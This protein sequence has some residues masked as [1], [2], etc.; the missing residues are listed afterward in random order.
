VKFGKVIGTV[1][2]TQK[3]DNLTGVKLLVI[4]PLAQDLTPKGPAYIAADA[5]GQAG[6]GQIVTI[7]FSADATQAFPQRRIPVDA[8]VVG[9]VDDCTAA[10]LSQGTR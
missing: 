3:D 1:V 9:I 2:S 10:R 4:Q 8:S 6:T 7:V 5:T